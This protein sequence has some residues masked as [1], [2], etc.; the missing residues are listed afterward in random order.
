MNQALIIGVYVFQWY[1]WLKINFQIPSWVLQSATSVTDRGI[2]LANACRAAGAEVVAAA[3]ATWRNATEATASMTSEASDAAERSAT[4][5][6][7]KDISLAIARRKPTGAT[8]KRSGRTF[9]K[10]S[11]IGYVLK[12]HWC[13]GV[14]ALATLLANAPKAPTNLH[15]I[16]A[17]R[18]DT[19]RA[20]VLR[21]WTGMDARCLATTATKLDTSRATARTAPKLVTTATRRATSVATATKTKATSL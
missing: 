15:V 19:S 10:I 11:I 7:V 5:A 16:T 4:N 17:I 12:P 6:T 9:N 1:N 14:T 2:M 3:V 21:A 8:G 13:L 18:W 20:T